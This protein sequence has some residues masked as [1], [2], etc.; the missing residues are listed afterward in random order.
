MIKNERLRIYPAS[1]EQMEKYIASEKDE[2]LRIPVQAEIEAHRADFLKEY[3][4]GFR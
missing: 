4:F 3:K 2:D 1:Q